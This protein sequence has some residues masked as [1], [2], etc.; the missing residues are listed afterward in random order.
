MKHLKDQI[1][2][3]DTKLLPIYG[4]KNITDYNYVLS[5]TD[6]EDLKIN[7][8]KLNEL[9][10]E[11]RK[12][13]HSKNFSL[14]KTKYKIETKSQAICLLKTCLETT[15]IPF[16]ICLKKNKK[17]LRLISKNNILDDYIN[18]LKMA[19]NGTFE[20]N[21]LN[22]SEPNTSTNTMHE[23]ISE[24][25]QKSE[26]GIE[27]E[28]EQVNPIKN[29][30]LNN[31]Y[32][33]LTGLKNIEKTIIITKEKLNEG[34][35]KINTFEFV[36]SPKKSIITVNLNELVIKINL[37]NGVLENKI[38]KSCCVK[39]I[40]KKINS[41][42]IISENIIDILT[43][44]IFG[45]LIVGGYVILS[46]KFTNGSNFIVDNVILPI[47]FLIYHTVEFHLVNIQEILH[48]LENFE[49]C[50]SGE[51]VNLYTELENSL[52]T[53]L[54]EQTMCVDNKYNTF[55]IMCGMGGNAYDK[56]VPYDK[57]IKLNDLSNRMSCTKD[58][59][60]YNKSDIINES[61]LFIGKPF[62]YGD[63]EGFEIT[64][65]SN[66]FIDSD[67]KKV[68]DYQYD[69]VYWNKYYEI[70]TIGTEYYRVNSGKNT[71]THN[72]KINMNTN[73]INT[74]SE[75]KFF[76]NLDFE[77]IS[78]MKIK[79]NPCVL[80]IESHN[81]VLDMDLKY[82]YKNGIIEFDFNN[83][84]LMLYGLIRDIII[85][86]DSESDEEPINCN[87][88]NVLMKAFKWSSKYVRFFIGNLY[89]PD[90][91]YINPYNIQ[92]K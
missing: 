76:I 45:K 40:S 50:I 8:S 89:C 62:S 37:K 56:F 77:K 55:R 85:S 70:Q 13:F 25:K 84:H 33:P 59:I 28:F 7:L 79:S 52:E 53:A 39:F 6:T 35:K 86:I 36:V 10:E 61:E 81:Y 58:I 47:K 74:I 83:K 17:F 14:H 27:Q 29:E 1:K 92:L 32:Y 42:P 82:T 38:L 51:Y 88:F 72:Y 67:A 44:N 21:F 43:K 18:H 91:V 41:Q 69:F 80:C 11:F 5:I 54:I 60:K 87:K 63:I 4:F 68:L 16:D 73:D 49:I 9:I 66:Q 48:L 75:L 23:F 30:D 3:I 24:S 78:N 15:S 26:Q 90:N 2:F 57:F 22:K 31:K 46:D 19:E 12:T 71:Y 64:N 65:F 34:I 20:T